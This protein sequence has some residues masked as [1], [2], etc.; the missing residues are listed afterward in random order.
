V[1]LS[2]RNLLANL[3]ALAAARQPVT[4]EAVLSTLPPSHAYELVAGQL[5]P[6]AAGA[7]VVYAGVPLPNRVLDAMR[8]ER[9]TRVVLVPA[10]FEALVRD[11]IDGLASKG[12]VDPEC[13]VLSAGELAAH[14]RGLTPEDLVRLRGAIRDRVGDALHAIVIG[15]AA[16]NP[17]WAE[18]M[19]ALG[20]H[21]DAGYGLTEAGPVVAMGRSG[22]CPPGSVGRPL[23]GVRVRISEDGEVLVHSESIMKGY[24]GDRAGTEACL[25]DGWLRTGDRGF[26]DAGGFLFITGR[27]KEAMV[28]SAGETIYPDEIEPYFASPFFAELAVVPA[29]GEHG[30][31]RP[32]LVVVPAD[33]GADVATLKQA[34]A[35]L[36]AAA[37]VRLRVSNV[38]VRT[39]PLPRTAVG[40]IRRRALADALVTSGV[41]S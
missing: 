2:H 16:T 20:I 21:L 25:D 22:E 32:T 10:L 41:A 27:I 1:A 15:G 13:R 24:A 36:N 40:K 39:E 35:R 12:V 8:R 23:Q 34:A 17:S 11:V 37:P 28:T 4:D 38:I 31:D 9:I 5:A 3:R 14:V 7:R 18:V 19:T 26:L 33:P 29:P 6:L 30:N